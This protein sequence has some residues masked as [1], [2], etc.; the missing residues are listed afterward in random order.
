MPKFILPIALVGLGVGVLALLFFPQY[1]DS[2][3]ARK[4]PIVELL[5]AKS[6]RDAVGS[7]P[8]VP[9]TAS[10]KLRNLALDYS[11][12]KN[13]R[14]FVALAKQHPELGGYNFAMQALANCGHPT[15][16][17]RELG[18]LPKESQAAFAK[19]KEVTQFWYHR[20]QSLLDSD[21]DVLTLEA[22]HKESLEKQDALTQLSERIEK[23]IAEK[24]R[25]EIR[26]ALNQLFA[27]KAPLDTPH[28]LYLVARAEA[29]DYS[30]KY[31]PKSGMWF[32]GKAHLE[33]DEQ[34]YWTA[35]D[36]I[37]C[38]FG[39]VC[40]QYDMY[41]AKACIAGAGCYN[42]R[43]EYIRNITMA[44]MFARYPE[45]AE[46]TYQNLIDVQHRIVAAIERGD[47]DAFMRP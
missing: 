1:Q 25:V 9:V 37:P 45:A 12:T 4:E 46:K 7:A 13:V 34:I 22:M 17:Y 38:S 33:N 19:R 32:E 14:A 2:E 29:S 11:Q 27:M 18:Y 47:V 35:L 42:N 16:Q 23:A 26:R 36:L 41:V 40:D 30:G 10:P 20:C 3:K 31:S 43:L 21:V 6:K 28:A 8:E 24:N 39:I 44:K 5:P 15:N